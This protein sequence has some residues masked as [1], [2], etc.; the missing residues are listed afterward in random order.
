MVRTVESTVCMAIE[1][2]DGPPCAGGARPGRQVLAPEMPKSG[3]WRSVSD[4]SAREQAPSPR[5]YPP[6]ARP[7]SAARLL[8]AS[9]PDWLVAVVGFDG[10]MLAKASAFLFRPKFEDHDGGWYMLR[11][12]PMPDWVDEGIRMTV[13]GDVVHDFQKLRVMMGT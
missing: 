10:T 6:V 9:A 13:N 4:V 1:G 5:R 8:G 3:G 12:L 7:E 2:V 11:S